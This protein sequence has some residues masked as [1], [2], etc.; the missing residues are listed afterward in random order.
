MEPLSLLDDE[1]IKK[2]KN[3]KLR[4]CRFLKALMPLV[5]KYAEQEKAPPMVIGIDGAWGSGK[6]SLLEMLQKKLEK[7]NKDKW[8]IINFSPWHYRN[9]KSLLMPLLATI[10]QQSPAF[11]QL[12]TKIVKL[13]PSFIKTLAAMGVETAT[14]G[15]PLLTF[16][17]NIKD[18]RK[19]NNDFSKMVEEAI[20]DAT[21]GGKKLVFLI[22]D[23]DRCDDGKQIIT[24]LEQIKLF[25]HHHNCLFFIAADQKRVEIAAKDSFAGAGAEYF[26][27]FIQA[28]FTL[29]PHIPRNIAEIIPLSDTKEENQRLLDYLARI[30]PL[31]DNNPRKLKTF[32]NRAVIH[33][34]IL[35]AEFGSGRI[36]EIKEPDF[37]LCLKWILMKE[38]GLDSEGLKDYLEFEK[39]VLKNL[40]PESLA[41]SNPDFFLKY[42]FIT[43]EGE[44]KKVVWDEKKK[45][46]I[47]FLWRDV[48]RHTFLTFPII[49]AYANV[50]LQDTT[51]S[52]NFL[53]LC[54]FEGEKCLKKRNFLYS[55]LR[56]IIVINFV[57]ENCSFKS[58]NMQN[59]ILKE[60]QFTKCDLS[61]L[62]LRSATLS[63]CTWYACRGLNNLTADPADWE[64]IL[65][66][67]ATCWRKSLKDEKLPRT[68]REEAEGIFIAYNA[69]LNSDDFSHTE[70]AINRLKDKRNDLRDDVINY[71]TVS[72]S[73]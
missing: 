2:S 34:G 39:G 28:S 36:D 13:G 11:D 26:E 22:D 63:N 5:E 62:D 30:A 52:R 41:N 60:V 61:G 18:G 17:Q 31:F 68:T 38:N 24:L 49:D 40:S 37:Y 71:Y 43:L 54:Q 70:E 51:R 4:F 33:F 6:T 23:L 42:K 57:F 12:V 32:W 8:V 53:E 72:L 46:F 55:D 73:S 56:D 66:T 16:L 1:P 44:E 65:D 7:E 48:H 9:E 10:A 3:D 50:A 14:T 67:A 25:L 35:Q 19:A 47:A 21:K 20:I 58:T 59:A 29:P 15:L 45:P 64:E 27:K 69:L